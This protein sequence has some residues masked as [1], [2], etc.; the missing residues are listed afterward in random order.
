V[1][2]VGGFVGVILAELVAGGLVLTWC[3]PLWNEAKRSY[4]TY[5]SGIL[6]GLFAVPSWLVLGAG[7]GPEDAATWATRLALAAALLIALTLAL[8][9]ARRHTAARVVG[10][11]S[12]P[13]A[14]AVLVA[15]AALAAQDLPL[16][17][18]QVGAGAFFLGSAYDMLFLGHWYLTDRK[19]SRR[20][21]QRATDLVLVA[22]GVEIVAIVVAGFDGGTVSPSLN[23][24]LA[25]GDVAPWI[26]IGMAVATLLI[27]VLAKA[28]LRG[29]RASA[30]QS[31]TGFSYLAV[32]TAIVGEIA[33]KTRFFPG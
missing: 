30:V 16:A 9:W 20:P 22:C 1:T 15:L 11:A 8:Q 18:V 24:V 33:V 28:A 19:L 13:V 2:G 32:L 7:A 12:V 27:A 5:Y 3:S 31:A 29:E 26:A 17:L 14:A 10:F 25:I 23:P 6:L 21:I 4:F